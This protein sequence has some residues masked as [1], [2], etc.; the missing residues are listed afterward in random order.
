MWFEIKGV[1]CVMTIGRDALWSEIAEM[2]AWRRRR[3]ICTWL[4]IGIRRPR[5]I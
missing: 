2:A 1:P 3:C 5:A 4:T